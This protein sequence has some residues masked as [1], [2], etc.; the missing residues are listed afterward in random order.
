MTRL[1]TEP[2]IPPLFSRSARQHH[3]RSRLRRAKQARPLLLSKTV[4]FTPGIDHVDVVEQP[5]EDSGGNH[6]V[7]EHLPPID[8]GLVGR[9][10]D[11]ATLVTGGDQ[12]E[13]DRGP[14]L[15]EEQ[16]AQ[17]VDDQELERQVEPLQF[18]CY[19]TGLDWPCTWYCGYHLMSC[20]YA[21]GWCSRSSR[22]RSTTTQQ[23]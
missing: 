14:H 21:L 19:T 5:V 20:T 13:E 23:V 17:L 6:R 10:G 22:A 16:I 2:S 18:P 7:T 12:L 1:E 9:Q 11:A 3:L 15:L 4:T 8:K